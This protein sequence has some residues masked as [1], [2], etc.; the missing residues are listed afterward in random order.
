MFQNNIFCNF[1]EKPIS[2]KTQYKCRID[3]NTRG[4]LLTKPHFPYNDLKQC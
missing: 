3:Y 4:N 2:L 1:I